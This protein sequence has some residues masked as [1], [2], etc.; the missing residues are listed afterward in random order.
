MQ[1]KN[2]YSAYLKNQSYDDLL[3]ISYSINQETQ[4]ERYAMVLAEIAEREKRGEKP[5][6]ESP[7][8]NTILFVLGGL[9]IFKSITDLIF[10]MGGWRP[11]IHLGL[12][13]VCLVMGWLGRRK[14]EVK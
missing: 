7:H 13:V 2:E 12:G 4:A 11:V 14:Q 10:S 6:P 9:F 8:Q 1:D 5:K 3:S